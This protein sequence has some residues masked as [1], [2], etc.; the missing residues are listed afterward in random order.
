MSTWNMPPGCSTNDIPGNESDDQLRAAFIESQGD[1]AGTIASRWVDELR[2]ED[3]D[4]ALALVQDDVRRR[5]ESLRI[6]LRG[7][8]RSNLNAFELAENV[9]D[10]EAWLE[11]YQ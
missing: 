4:S 3:Q 2:F 1:A 11:E 9:K 10:F 7:I 5:R 8:L 6:Q